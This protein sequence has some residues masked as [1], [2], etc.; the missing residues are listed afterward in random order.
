LER[1]NVEAA[2][3]HSSNAIRLKNESINFLRLSSRLDACASRVKGAQMM[4]TVIK[5]MSTVVKGMD[6]ALET[7]DPEKIGM[8]MDKFEQ[9]VEG[10]DVTTANMESSMGSVTAM[11]TPEDEVNC[12]FLQCLSQGKLTMEISNEQLS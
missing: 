2:R 10:L 7:M 1:G 3:I 4:E 5:T 8:V 9:Q 12:R 6:K 11:S